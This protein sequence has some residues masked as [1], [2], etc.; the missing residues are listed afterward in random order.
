MV[1]NTLL[2]QKQ[3]L[4]LLQEPPAHPPLAY[5]H[6]SVM[7]GSAGCR[8]QAGRSL[9][10][11]SSGSDFM[12]SPSP[13]SSS[14]MPK[15]N[16]HLGVLHYSPLRCAHLLDSPTSLGIPS[17]GCIQYLDQDKS[18]AETVCSIGLDWTHHG[19]DIVRYW[20]DPVAQGEALQ[21]WLWM[22][23]NYQAM[24][25]AML[26]CRSTVHNG[27]T[28]SVEFISLYRVKKFAPSWL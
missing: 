1:D 14:P 17:C 11:E 6:E 22:S 25:S 12:E 26:A 3:G 21:A 15:M 27:G 8:A 7:H 5:G 23:C 10:R 16:L 28:I 20:C 4:P 19:G 18:S 9:S 24:A 13:S 2:R